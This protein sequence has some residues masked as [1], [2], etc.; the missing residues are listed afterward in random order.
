MKKEYNNDDQDLRKLFH[1]TPNFK[2]DL[3]SSVM[4]RLQ[5]ESKP[6]ERFYVKYKVSLLVLAGMLLT[7]SS[8][9]AAVKYHS[10]KNSQGEVV[11]QEKSISEAPAIANY[12]DEERKRIS[13]ANQAYDNL[14]KGT[15]MLIYVTSHNP[16]QQ[17]D[18]RFTPFIFKNAADLRKKVNNLDIKLLDKIEGDYTFAWGEA[19]MS[20]ITDVK[21]LTSEEEAAIAEKLRK[22]ALASNTDYAM[23]P[24]E[25]A[26][27]FRH[28]RSFYKQGDKEIAVTTVNYGVGHG[29]ATSYWDDQLDLI[30]EKI[31]VKGIE[32]IY[33]KG[34]DGSPSGINWVDQDAK[35]GQ[36]YGYTVSVWE[37]NVTEQELLNVVNM[38]LN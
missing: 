38:Y 34:S 11:Y 26:D 4:H 32:M 21:P 36:T 31:T 28:I 6:K 1:N 20:P 18:M 37:G 22:E 30:K 12:T 24:I 29:T 2:T 7:V 35:T 9:F 19:F 17:L 3:T 5:S 15:A 8:G 13:I 33:T 23:M 27:D 16:G 10:L 14:D 25:F